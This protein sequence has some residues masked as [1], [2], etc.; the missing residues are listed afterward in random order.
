[1]CDV[2][3]RREFLKSLTTLAKGFVSAG[4]LSRF[5][6][7]TLLEHTR[8][9]DEGSAPKSE[10]V[11]PKRKLGGT[12]VDISLIGLGGQA[13]LEL[14]TETQAD[15]SK[16]I[17]ALALDLGVNFIDT[18]PLHG[19]GLSEQR[20]GDALQSRRD[21]VFLASKTHDRTY[22]GTL[23]L[24][25][26]SL[27]RLRTGFLNLYQLSDVNSDEDLDTALS[28]NGAI[29][30]IQRLQGERVVRHIGIAGNRDPRVLL[31]AIE[32]HP[33]D[34]ILIPLN[35]ADIHFQPFQTEL[36]A[37]ASRKGMGIL[38]T[39][40]TA[41]NKVFRNDGLSSIHDALGYVFS[42]P[43]TSA[44]LDVASVREAEEA[45]AVAKSFHG[46]WAPAHRVAIEEQTRHYWKD[47]NW[48]KFDPS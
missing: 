11:M 16:T 27:R 31:R 48:Y 15:I 32:E 20:I 21:T 38:A 35:A 5:A 29:R 23:R 26:Q 43:I 13:A 9:K 17:L 41:N 46:P 40:V 4:L 1:M 30:A 28:R 8:A 33:F 19:D 47:A 22:D 10:R 37:T 6:G 36:L 34:T 3:Y 7:S 25:E 42:L 2:Q 39:H 14:L 18:A 24:A 44:I 12:G 45:A